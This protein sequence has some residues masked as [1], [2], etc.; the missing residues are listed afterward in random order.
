MCCVG[1]YCTT[2]SWYSNGTTGGYVDEKNPGQQKPYNWGDE[3][4]VY[5]GVI[6]LGGGFKY[7]LF[8]SLFGEMIQFDEYFLNGLKPPTRYVYT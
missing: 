3:C 4:S 6:Y 7:F 2:L 1:G 8:S 5:L